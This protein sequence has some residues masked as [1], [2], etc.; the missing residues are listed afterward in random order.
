[1]EQDD[2]YWNDY[3]NYYL[4]YYFIGAVDPSFEV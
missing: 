4:D 1:M 3:W 2:Y